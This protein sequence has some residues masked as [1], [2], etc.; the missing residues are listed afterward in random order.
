MQCNKCGNLVEYGINVCPSCGNVMPEENYILNLT[1]ALPKKQETK[2][3]LQGLLLCILMVK[4][5]I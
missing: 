1:R 4:W 2:Q 5:I 3:V